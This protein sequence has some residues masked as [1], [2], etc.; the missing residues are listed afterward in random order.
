MRISSFSE[1]GIHNKS[2]WLKESQLQIR[3]SKLL[4]DIGDRKLDDALELKP[5]IQKDRQKRSEI[6]AIWEDR[7]AVYKSSFLLLGYSFELLLKAGILRIY[8]GIPKELFDSDIKSKYGHKLR[9]MAQDLSINLNDNELNHLDLLTK[10]LTY[11]ARYPIDSDNAQHY[12][13][14]LNNTTHR[15]F[16]GELYL[17]YIKLYNKISEVI[18]KIDSS[19]RDPM[20]HFS[21]QIDEDGYFSY[22][23]GGEL[24]PIMIY[25]FSKKQIEQGTN[26]KEQLYNLLMSEICNSVSTQLIDKDWNSAKHIEHKINSKGKHLT[27]G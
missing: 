11:L 24:P 15:Y 20:S 19:R 16:D 17:K 6:R 27:R 1:K 23:F 18:T 10:D 8:I 9:K 5:L 4:R 22:R 13:Q 25:R 26:T 2:D 21:Y 3:S 12:S 7:E 14:A